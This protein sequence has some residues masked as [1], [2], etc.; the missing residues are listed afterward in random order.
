MLKLLNI[1]G[2]VLVII[3]VASSQ[4]DKG[5]QEHSLRYTGGDIVKFT[6]RPLK[7]EEAKAIDALLQ[8]ALDINNPDRRSALIELSQSPHVS[9][10]KPLAEFIRQLQPKH[11]KPWT[12]GHLGRREVIIL[13]RCADLEVVDLLIEFLDHPLRGVRAEALE[14]LQKLIV[15]PKVLPKGFRLGELSWV[16]LEDS[17][18]RKAVVKALKEWWQANKGKVKIRWA[19]AW[20]SH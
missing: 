5:L 18:K 13:S 14:N 11:E 6:H 7:P 19:E 8:Q 16:S 15:L 1:V 12:R 17:D 10:I 9:L 3:G 20:L 4:A 2:L